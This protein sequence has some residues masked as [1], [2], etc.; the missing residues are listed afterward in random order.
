MKSTISTPEIVSELEELTKQI[1][2]DLDILSAS[3]WKISSEVNQ[4]TKKPAKID[5]LEIY[6][7][8]KSRLTELAKKH[9]LKAKRFTLADGDLSAEK[10]QK[11]L[12]EVLER[13][14]PRE[15]W[16]APE[17]GPWGNFSRLNMCRS[18]STMQKILDSRERQ[19]LHLRLCNEVYH[20]QVLV[21]RHFHM[22]Q[23]QGSEVFD[24]PEV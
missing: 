20:F 19:R 11:A 8:E 3:A 17:C 7:N 16:M 9:G 15:I 24:Q 14:Q 23:P 2:R 21:G 1:E 5:I 13:E 10:G 12:W 18:S 6:C 22:E 4:N